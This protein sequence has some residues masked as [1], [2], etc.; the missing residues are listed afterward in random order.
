MSLPNS[1]GLTWRNHKK[2]L[3]KATSVQNKT[4]CALVTGSSSG[5]GLAV[6]QHLLA[7]GWQVL[8]WD[9]QAPATET[10][11]HPQFVHTTVDLMD[12]AAIAIAL[13]GQAQR[14]ASTESN[15]PITAFIHAAGQMFTGALPQLNPHDGAAMWRLHVHAATVIAQALTPTMQATGMGRIVLLGSR[16][17]QG[18]AQR[19]QYAAVKAALIALA[20][21]WA[22]ELAASGITVN[23][24]SPAATRTAMLA[25]SDRAS[26]APK[27]PPIGRYIEPAEV[28][29]L[30]AYV[31]SPAAA[32][33]TGQNL[34][35]CGGSSL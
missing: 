26:S 34:Q 10:L 6:S 23:V 3:L 24:V 19:S 21:S 18:M 7:Q 29:S 13:S 16:V 30:I 33:I 31:L 12:D 11:N 28:A 2:L 32:A 20:K 4:L 27:L 14:Q 25:S 35:I 15:T 22:A 9:K 8:G 1:K 17:A 5:I